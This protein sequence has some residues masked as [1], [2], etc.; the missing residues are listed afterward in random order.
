[1]Q[2]E[3][4]II[5]QQEIIDTMKFIEDTA[6][7]MSK[8]INDFMNF[9]KPTYKK[10]CIKFGRIIEDILKMM[11]A[12]LK[13]HNIKVE[14][15]YEDEE[16]LTFCKE[17]EHILINI[18]A[19]ARDALDERKIKDKKIILKAYK[20]DNDFIIEIIDNAGGI[21]E[22]IMDRIFE[23]YFTTKEEGKG[24]GLGLYM[25]KK[26]LNNTIGGDISVENVKD[27]AKFIITL[28]DVLC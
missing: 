5:N 13:N 8:I 2:A 17:L 12:Q 20:K 15:D 18:L 7:D 22:E 28:K 21:K 3:M 19:N 27:G 1:M 23:P 10:E 26:I 11:G 24:T 6:Q 25:S 4:G 16:I 14:F 9:T